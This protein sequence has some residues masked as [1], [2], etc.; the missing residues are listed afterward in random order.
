MLKLIIGLKGSGKTKHLIEMANK[1]VEVS[2]GNVVCIEKSNKLT[3]DVNHKVRLLDTDAYGIANA[4][5]LYGLVC[6]IL[7]TN[8]DVKDLFIDSALKICGDDVARWTEFVAKVD[9]LCQK[10]EVQCV[11]T[12]SIDQADLPKSLDQ[13]VF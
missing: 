5:E 7:A 11:M 9:H 1:A 10:Y 8:Y 2:P 6:G 12:S 4:Q 13:Y 3:F